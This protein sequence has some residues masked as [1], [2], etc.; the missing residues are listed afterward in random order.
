M[1]SL[2]RVTHP[3]RVNRCSTARR[4]PVGTH[5]LCVRCVKGYSVVVLTGTDAQIV[6]PYKG[7]L[8][9]TVCPYKSLHVCPYISLLVC[10]YLRGDLRVPPLGSSRP[11]LGIFA[12]PRGDF[13]IPPL[14]LFR[15]NVGGRYLSHKYGASSHAD[16]PLRGGFT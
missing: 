12:S 11:S 4:R 1:L 3:I 10:A 6:R 7:L 8:V 13:S 9:L 16:Y 15:P 14:G 5:G 2:V